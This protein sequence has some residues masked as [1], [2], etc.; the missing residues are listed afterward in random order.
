[1]LIVAVKQA[2]VEGPAGV[3]A[4][5]T[6]LAKGLDVS[7]LKSGGLVVRAEDGLIRTGDS[8][9]V[10]AV[11]SWPEALA[12]HELMEEAGR[13]E[14]CN[15]NLDDTTFDARPVIV[16]TDYSL[17]PPPAG[18]LGPAVDIWAR[19]NRTTAGAGNEVFA[20]LSVGILGWE[21]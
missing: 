1:M 13:T 14:R 15:V 8:I 10:Y 20:T 18:L 9:E 17:D 2:V 4:S 19:C 12:P 7:R 16:H 11:S 6:L 5:S 21:A 3:G